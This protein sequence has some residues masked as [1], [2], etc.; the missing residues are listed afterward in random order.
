MGEDTLSVTC[1][2]KAKKVMKEEAPAAN[3]TITPDACPD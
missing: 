1:R 3:T 2:K